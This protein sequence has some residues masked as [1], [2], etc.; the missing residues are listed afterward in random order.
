MDE[1][2]TTDSSSVL[3]LGSLVKAALEGDARGGITNLLKEIASLTKSFGCVLWRATLGAD[4]PETGQLTMLAAWFPVEKSHF[5]LKS[6]EFRETVVGKAA[7][8]DCGWAID[9]DLV[10]NKNPH[11]KSPFFTNNNLNRVVACRF[12]FLPRP[13]QAPRLGVVLIFRKASDPEF[14]ERMDVPTLQ[15]I[16]RVLPF[17]YSGARQK[18]SYN[19][20]KEVGEILRDSR[21]NVKP[22]HLTPKR[23][24]NT[25]LRQVAKALV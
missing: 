25:A 1:P 5:G 2:D 9:N 18:A 24:Q 12:Y 22:G 10:G 7:S 19:L 3:G 8:K 6:A 23:T 14:D 17:L 11:C 13:E 21:K 15:Q 16:S 20:L 4:P